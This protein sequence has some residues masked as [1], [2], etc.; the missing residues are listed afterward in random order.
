MWLVVWNVEHFCFPYFENFIIPTGLS[1]FSEGLK[2]PTSIFIYI[3]I[4]ILS[5]C[6]SG[7]LSTRFLDIYIYIYIIYIRMK[8]MRRG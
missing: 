6:Y 1:C 8:W 3:Y 4:Y 2:P 7:L 5:I